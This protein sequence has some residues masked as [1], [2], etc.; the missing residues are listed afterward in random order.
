MPAFLLDPKPFILRGI[1]VA[2]IMGAIIGFW[3]FGGFFGAMLGYFVAG[4][5]NSG[6]QANLRSGYDLHS[7]SGD[8]FFT[9]VFSLMGHIAKAD[10]KVSQDEIDQAEI[11]MNKLG[12]SGAKRQQAI[13]CFKQGTSADFDM[14]ALLSTFSSAVRF[15]ADLKQNLLMFLVE[16][17]IADDEFHA[18][19]EA[20]LRRVAQSIAIEMRSFERMVEMLKAQRSFAGGQSASGVDDLA[21]AYK[22]MGVDASISDK[23]LKRAYRKLMSQHHPDKM[24][25]KGVPADMVAMATEK[26]QEIQAAYDLIERS[27][28]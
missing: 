8:I 11:M 21:T 3:L 22:A 15:R 24:I 26:T 12:V 9:T 25:A 27:R 17:A 20:I 5:F 1:A 7:Q 6:L 16:M 23:D 13:E 14:A 2:K 19:E 10:G 28:K 18:S 4:F